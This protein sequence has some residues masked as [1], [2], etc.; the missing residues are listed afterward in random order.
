MRSAMILT[1]FALAACTVWADA[2]SYRGQGDASRSD[3]AVDTFDSG[4][5]DTTPDLVDAEAD[6]LVRDSGPMLDVGAADVMVDTSMPDAGE[7][8]GAD[9]GRPDTGGPDT[10]GPDAGPC[11]PGGPD[12]DGDGIH[13]NC[14][15]WPC[16]RR[17]VIGL[18][19]SAEFITIHDVR[20]NRMARTNTVVV[21]SDERFRMDITWEIDDTIC[22]DCTDRIEIGF[23][24]IGRIDCIYN[25]I[26]PA[27]GTTGTAMIPNIPIPPGESGLFLL[28]YNFGEGPECPLGGEWHNGE[29]GEAQ[30]IGAVCV[31][32]V[33]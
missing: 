15:D 2:D 3:V 31:V 24:D 13:D 4:P 21:R 17:P 22:D 6:A 23:T 30:T 12:A 1:L 10:G 19:N 26:P 32:A 33:P 14:D 29:P 8:V 25:D 18:P 5:G 27:G 11:P 16:G 7:D 28:R 9:A 20:M